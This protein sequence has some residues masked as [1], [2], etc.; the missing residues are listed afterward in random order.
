MKALI[1]A[2]SALATAATAARH[3]AEP[4]PPTADQ[5]A[6]AVAATFPSYDLNGDGQL[7]RAEF[8]QMM[9]RLKTRTD[10]KASPTRAWLSGA[11]ASAD[12]DRSRSVT[13]QELTGFLIEARS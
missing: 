10:P 8:A 7:S 1:L 12:Q 5:V 2:A 11:F 3:R 9:T 6:A 13:R 4:A